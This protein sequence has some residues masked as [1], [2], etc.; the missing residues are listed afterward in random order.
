ME[1]HSFSGLWI[2]TQEFANLE[3]RNVFHRQLDTSVHLPEEHTNRHI[4]F[5]K[6][7]NIDK[8]FH[9][10][11]MYITAD[12]Y[13]KLYINGCF[14]M[15]GPAPC[16]PFSYG[17]QTL[18]VSE[19]LQEGDNIIAVHTYYQGLINRVWVSGDNRHGLICDLEIDGKICLSSDETF[20]TH[21]HSGYEAMG[22]VGYKTQFLERYDSNA[23]EVGFTKYAFDDSDWERAKV[24]TCVDYEL[25]SQKTKN[26]VFEQI[27][28][29]NIIR[30]GNRIF[31]DFGKCYVGYLN[32]EVSRKQDDTITIRC[33][34][35]L[36]PDGTV[37]YQ[38]RAN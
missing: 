33:G 7:L 4:L 14:V 24:R 16:Y 3:P 27:L 8:S 17:Y 29:Q 18:D 32:L 34:Q 28:P 5:R 19:F 25:V 21:I 2:T 35:E 36:N 26:L 12:D 31:V 38:L 37:R 6:K 22:T 23:E 20:L 15:Q 9:K 30:D 11:T 10:A 1:N 13:Y